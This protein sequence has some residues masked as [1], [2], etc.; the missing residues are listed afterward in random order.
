MQ[1]K[2]ELFLPEIVSALEINELLNHFRVYKKRA[3]KAQTGGQITT[4]G[5][6][7]PST[8]SHTC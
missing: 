1:I 4:D 6:C 3:T 5:Q 8:C 7:Y 2:L